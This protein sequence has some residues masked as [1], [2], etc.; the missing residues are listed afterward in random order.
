MF[1]SSQTPQNTEWNSGGN[2]ALSPEGLAFRQA[3]I[4]A[5]LPI[6]IYAE[7]GEILVLS[8]GWIRLTGYSIEDIPTLSDWAHKAYGQQSADV[9]AHIDGLFALNQTIDEGEFTLTTK[10]GDQRVWQ[11]SSSPLGQ[12]TDG[13][14]LV[15]SMAAD[16]TALKAS[17]QKAEAL[18][19]V[20]EL[21]IAERTAKLLEANQD[22]EAFT[23]TVSHD[24]RAPLRAME[25]FAKALLEDY[26]SQLESVASDYAERIVIAATR[27][28]DLVSDLLDYSQ[29]SRRALGIQPLSVGPIIDRVREDIEPDVQL[30]QA[31]IVVA[32]DLIDICGNSYVVGRI[33]TNLLTN[34]I[35]FVPH[36][37][38]PIVTISCEETADR[39]RYW[40]SDNGLGIATDHHQRIFSMFERL[41]DTEDYPGTG[42]GLA[43]VKRGAQKMGGDAGVVSTVGQGSRFWVD[44][45]KVT[46][47]RRLFV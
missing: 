41:Y 34:G 4:S 25:G 30:C 23:Y 21:R 31:Q 44:F 24:L 46:D 17:E 1:E 27:M 19:Q 37:V 29:M 45:V 22:L 7:D 20:L 43:I 16:V 32:N 42:V 36:N 13:R 2:R 5:P 47:P 35:K 10:S 6:L 38:R 8:E 9:L 14:R 15:M 18:N 40:V 28:D 39:I 11:F 33:F 26:A 12:L 3:V